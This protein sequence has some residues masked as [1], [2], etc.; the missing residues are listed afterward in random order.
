MCGTQ[1]EASY[2][3]DCQG[4]VCK[5]DSITFLKEVWLNDQLC[6]T[7]RL[8][9]KIVREYYDKDN[10]RHEFEIV[11]ENNAKIFIRGKELHLYEIKRLPW[12]NENKRNQVL[13]EK[14]HRGNL[15]RSKNYDRVGEVKKI[16]VILCKSRES[17]NNLKKVL[18]LISLPKIR[19]V[20]PQ[21]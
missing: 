16:S 13:G 21:N 4:D 2:I 14:H 6:G 8:F 10:G 1:K 12:E 9:G 19:Y 3:I 7:I 15:N 20:C 18:K 5:G 11:L 17:K